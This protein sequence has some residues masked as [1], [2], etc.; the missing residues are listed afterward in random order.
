M[1]C[2]YQDNRELNDFS[3]NGTDEHW[4]GDTLWLILDTERVSE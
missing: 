4:T 1:D 2:Q 3:Q